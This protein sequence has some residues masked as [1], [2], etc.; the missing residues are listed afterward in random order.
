MKKLIIVGAG[1]FGREVYNWAMDVQKVN[2]EWKIGGFLDKN[3]RAL[4][5]YDNYSC[6][7]LAIRRISTE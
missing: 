1:G 6:Q 5:K 4:E 2:N 7:L 3:P